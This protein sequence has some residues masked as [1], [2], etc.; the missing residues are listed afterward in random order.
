MINLTETN[1]RYD[2]TKIDVDKKYNLSRHCQQETLNELLKVD[3]NFFGTIQLNYSKHINSSLIEKSFRFVRA[4]KNN[5]SNDFSGE[6]Q[7]FIRPAHNGTFHYHFLI[8]T[9]QTLVFKRNTRL[10]LLLKKIETDYDF[11][12]YLRLKKKVFKDLKDQHFF[13][14]AQLDL[15]RAII[16]KDRK[17]FC[18][19]TVFN[20]HD[21]ALMH[22]VD[23][24]RYFTGDKNF[25]FSTNIWS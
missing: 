16:D 6:H 11:A 5:I 23:L 10:S 9:R 17:A 1:L 15:K 3:F 18:T 8:K 24:K 20:K 4:V 14:A 25:C 12:S 13:P 7:Y 22:D 2:S 21:P 19:Y